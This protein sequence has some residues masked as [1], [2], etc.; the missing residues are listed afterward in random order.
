VDVN[1]RFRVTQDYATKHGFV[2][3]VPTFYVADNPSNV[4]FGALLISA[5]AAE[6]RDVPVSQLGPDVE[7][8]MPRV[9]A[10]H[11][12]AT[13]RGFV[14]GFPT[15]LEN[16]SNNDYVYGTLL[17]KA[18]RA[19]VYQPSASNLGNP[20][21]D[22]IG[23]RF[24]ATQRF[25]TGNG[26]LGGYPTFEKQV[27]L[28]TPRTVVY[29]T[30]LLP[31]GTVEFRDIP[32][33]ELDAP[34]LSD[35]AHHVRSMQRYAVENG[36][37]GA[38]PTFFLAEVAGFVCGTLLLDSTGAEWRDIDIAELQNVAP[39]DQAGRFRSVQDYAKANKFVGGYPNFFIGEKATW[40]LR[41]KHK[42]VVNGT[43]LVRESVASWRDI[44]GADLGNPADDDG[45][46]RFRGAQDYAVFKAQAVGGFPNFYQAQTR[47]GNIYGTILLR[48]PGVVFRDVNYREIFTEA[49]I[50]GAIRDHWEALGGPAG[51][52]GLPLTEELTCVDGKGRFNR[53][54][55]G[56]IYF[57][58]STGALEVHGAILRRWAALG[59]E[60]S[61]LGY[62]TSDEAPW[63]NPFDGT[64]GRVSRFE[65]GSI[66]WTDNTI[67]ELP[68]VVVSHK[69]VTTPAGTAL[70]G[71]V[72]LT[73][74]SNGTYSFLIH[75]HDSGIPNY[76]FSVRASFIT[77]GGLTLVGGPWKGTV[78][79]SLAP[80]S[81]DFNASTDGAEPL[82]TKFW[83]EI[84]SGKL[85]VVKDY[86][87]PGILGTIFD[88][89][90]VILEGAAGAAG[91]SVGLVI[92]LGS[93]VASVFPS[94]GIGETFGV[95]G[96]II[97]FAGG[98]CLTF[99]IVEGIAIGAITDAMIAS[100]EMHDDEKD[101]VREKVFDKSIALDNIRLT[102]LSGLGGRAFT[103]PGIDG[104]TYVNL[105]SDD[106]YSNPTT[107]TRSATDMPGQLLIHE[108]THAWQIEHR[109]FL[110]GVVCEGMVNQAD[111]IVGDDVYAYG[112]AGPA[113]REF[114]LERQASIV[115]NWFARGPGANPPNPGDGDPYFMY[116]RD[117]IRKGLT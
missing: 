12:Y 6:W 32:S 106:A 66:I 18:H 117:N 56:V 4:V 62:P 33:R 97:V 29:N 88:V 19:K 69:D 95:I 10:V 116:I 83:N 3:G 65:R 22:D 81:R 11:T 101:F 104:K 46:A 99:A 73:L 14:S 16:I 41:G 110:P 39:E 27:Q 74:K 109:T 55:G 34:N 35:P 111:Y 77:P 92:G 63:T 84:I 54:E 15:F 72:D 60:R 103:M 40:D 2:G 100:R 87:V 93:D 61:Y 86:S 50:R 71:W 45:P 80:G 64:T 79:G 112:P 70:G 114:G 30:V 49:Y 78:A 108:L 24:R 17:F 23:E 58:P 89:S 59:Y 36:F 67:I 91:F 94:L 96:G 42:V 53:F 21:D 75:M 68:D 115:D 20:L 1:L 37:I 43:I 102:N 105:A 5:E 113:W 52:L 8:F 44:S 76:D 90:K 48:G 57:L 9:T 7:A 13:R 47:A 98:G 25:A 85:S 26:F 107:H 28:L 38:I 51:F 31:R 82:I